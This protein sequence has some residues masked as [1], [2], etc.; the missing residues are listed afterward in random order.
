MGRYVPVPQ[1]EYCKTSRRPARNRMK[2]QRLKGNNRLTYRPHS[3]GG[4]LY[5]IVPGQIA[6]RPFACFAK[7]GLVRIRTRITK[8]DTISS[9]VPSDAY[10][11][12]QGS[13]E[14][15]VLFAHPQANPEARSPAIARTEWGSR[16]ASS[17]GNRAG[18]TT[19]GE[20]VVSGRPQVA[21]PRNATHSRS[22]AIDGPQ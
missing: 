13:H 7:Q 8:A 18:P 22:T 11:Q 20:V 4:L 10:K 12:S 19:N 2:P 15:D 9:I 16:R 21:G 1:T 3:W 17:G 6:K 14:V 5:G